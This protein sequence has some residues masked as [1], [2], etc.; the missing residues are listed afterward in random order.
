MSEDAPLMTNL[1]QVKAND[2]DSNENGQIQ[3]QLLDDQ[4]Y[5]FG[6]N[7]HTGHLFLRQ[8]LDRELQDKY[9]F[10]VVAMDHGKVLKFY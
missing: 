4:L 2:I 1:F 9:S 3:Y 6:I 8:T 5:Y 10:L 7:S